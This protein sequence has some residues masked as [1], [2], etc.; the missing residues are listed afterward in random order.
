MSSSEMSLYS[1]AILACDEV[2][3]VLDESL[4]E[5]L[6]DELSLSESEGEFK[7]DLMK[8]TA[9]SISIKKKNCTKKLCYH[10]D[11]RKVDLSKD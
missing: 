5:V 11:V 2:D 3:E 1:I 4:D 10:E 6:D 7:G 8:V 9:S